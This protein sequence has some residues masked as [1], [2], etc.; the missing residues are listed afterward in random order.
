MSDLP[1][2][3]W[4]PPPPPKRAARARPGGHAVDARLK[5]AL[6][7]VVSG[8]HCGRDR[9]AT[10]EALREELVAEGVEVGVVR[11][12]Q[13]AAEELLGEGHPV[14]GL[15]S[16]GVFYAVEADELEAALK[17][18]EQRARRTLRRRRLLRRALL[19]ML[20]QVDIGERGAA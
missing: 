5:A 11:R 20:G 8:R 18:S 12:C 10:W 19:R 7:L 16:A 6:L 3:D 17:E 13:E 4:R 14:V 1:L 2:L 9:A 15:S